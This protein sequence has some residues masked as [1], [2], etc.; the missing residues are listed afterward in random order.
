MENKMEKTFCLPD[1]DTRKVG[2]PL[3]SVGYEMSEEQLGSTLAC[4]PSYA[5]TTGVTVRPG[6]DAFLDE[7]VKIKISYA[8]PFAPQMDTS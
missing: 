2:L 6:L 3:N 4:A 7:L 1:G 8:G 5:K